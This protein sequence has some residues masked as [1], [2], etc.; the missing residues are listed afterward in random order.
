MKWWL[1]PLI[2][3]QER[4][5]RPKVNCTAMPVEQEATEQMETVTELDIANTLMNLFQPGESELTTTD[6]DKIRVLSNIVRIDV[7]ETT[8][9]TNDE[10]EGKFQNCLI[11]PRSLAIFYLTILSV[12]FSVMSFLTPFFLLHR[13][14]KE[15]LYIKAEPVYTPEASSLTYSE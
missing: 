6:G 3:G 9:K 14:P 15:N 13:K 4:G 8:H 1:L 2:L 12:A 11:F 10:S 7:D 5:P